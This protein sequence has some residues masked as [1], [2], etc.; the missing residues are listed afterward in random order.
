[1][2]ASESI[3]QMIFLETTTL[4]V[5]YHEE[6]RKTLERDFVEVEGA[7]VKLAYRSSKTTAKIEMDDLREVPG[8]EQRAYLRSKSE[9]AA[10]EKHGRC[11]CSEVEAFGSEPLCL[12][13][14]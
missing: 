2:E 3:I 11:Q 5:R 9:N 10:L 4:G 7:R 14:W 8:Y 13:G 6:S 12:T 1:M